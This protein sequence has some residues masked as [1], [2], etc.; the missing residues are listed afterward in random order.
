MHVKLLIF[1]ALMSAILWHY[2][3]PRFWLA[4][5]AATVTTVTVFIV[6]LY[7]VWIDLGPRTLYISYFF[8][9]ETLHT[10]FLSAVLVFDVISSALLALVLAILIGWFFRKQRKPG[11]TEEHS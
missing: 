7:S 1:L 3:V 11:R 5:A 6:S 2:F 10:D 4:V 8:L 9:A